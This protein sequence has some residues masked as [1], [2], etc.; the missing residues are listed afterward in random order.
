MPKLANV[1]GFENGTGVRRSNRHFVGDEE[2][3]QERSG[4]SILTLSLA[5]RIA[6]SW[7][8]RR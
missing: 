6:R 4:E 5:E 2:A 8:K 7:L 3:L 1:D